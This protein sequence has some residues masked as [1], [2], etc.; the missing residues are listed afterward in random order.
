MRT[1][2]SFRSRTPLGAQPLHERAHDLVLP[3][4]RG[5]GQRLHDEVVAVAVD[6][7]RGQPV[8]FAVDE[9]AGGRAR[10]HALAP[11]D[12]P[13]QAVRE[14]RL[15]ERLPRARSCAAGSRSATSRRRS[16]GALPRGPRPAPPLPG[17]RPPPGG[18]RSGTPRDGR[19][20][21]ARCPCARR[22]PF[23]RPMVASGAAGTILRRGERH[24]K[25][26]PY[27][28]RGRGRRPQRNRPRGP[29]ARADRLREL[30]LRSGAGGAGHGP[31]QQVRRGLP[32]QALLRRLRGRGRGGEPGHRAR[33]AALR[34]RPRQRPA[35]LRGPG[36]HRRLHDRGQARATPS[37]A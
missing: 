8:A 12:G 4:V 20:G 1:L 34:R 31:H 24:G 26:G 29:A 2:G 28:S 23:P 14:E 22:R 11:L 21:C 15:R 33:Q 17:E 25:P 35:A 18:C 10:R 16:P 32:G 37:S 36:Q 19:V 13:P 6:D 3:P 9:P 5:L 7:Q 30:R 27:R